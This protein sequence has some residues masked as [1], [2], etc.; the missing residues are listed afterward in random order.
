MTRRR[1]FLFIVIALAIAVLLA[2]PSLF[3]TGK[4]QRDQHHSAFTNR[5]HT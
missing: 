3:A 1:T 4:A 5:E 2:S